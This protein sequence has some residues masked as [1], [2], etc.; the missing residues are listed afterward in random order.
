MI[1]LVSTSTELKQDKAARSEALDV[2]RSFL[3][4]APAG[5]GKTEL[6]TRRFLALLAKANTPEEILAITFTRDATAEM[7]A[8]VLE[9]LQKAQLARDAGLPDIELASAALDRS[10]ERDWSLLQ[11]PHRLNI[12][13]I[14]SLC[15]QIAHEAPL[16]SRLG[17]Q[18]QPTEDVMPLYELAARRTME[19]LDSRDRRLA[20]A[21]QDLLRLR[22]VNV[23]ECET[24]IA[25]MLCNRDQWLAEFPAE[26]L[27]SDE[28][29]EALRP[30]LEDPLRREHTRV[31]KRLKHLLSR[32]PSHG[33]ELFRLAS[34]ACT[35]NPK[36]SLDGLLE[37][38]S[39]DEMATL[40][41]FACARNFLVTADETWRKQVNVAQGFPPA[42]N[43]GSQQHIEDF[44]KLIQELQEID[45]L[46]ETFGELKSLPAESYTDEEW[47][48]I[49][50]IFM[51]L[52]HAAAQLRL[53]FAEKSRIDFVEVGLT[54]EYALQDPEIRRRWSD[55]VHHFLVDE[56]QDTSRRQYE[57]LHSI[58]REWDPS[59]KKTCFLVGDPMQSIYLF[60]QADVALFKEVQQHGFGYDAASVTFSNLTLKKN[61]RST[62]GIVN[63][64][65][66]MFA[67][68]A[69]QNAGGWDRSQFAPAIADVETP[70][71]NSVHVIAEFKDEAARI[72]S[73]DAEAAQ[74][75]EIIRQHLPAMQE[76]RATGKEFRVGVLVRAKKHVVRIAAELRKAGI[77]YRAIEIDTLTD[78]QEIKDLLS[79]VR[80]LLSPLDRIAW[81]SILRAPWC[82]L[83]LS[84]LHLLSGSDDKELLRR[85]MAEL[86]GTRIALLSKDGAQ[87]AHRLFQ[88]M[89]LA[90]SQRF[91]GEFSAS[92]S[93]FSAWIERTWYSL[94][95][96][97]CLDSNSFENAQAFFKQLA[98]ITPD[99]IEAADTLLQQRMARL[100]AQPSTDATE[101]VGVQLM[102]IHKSKGLG[103]DVVLVPALE[104]TTGR[105]MSPLLQWMAHT[106]RDS[107]Q[108]ELLLAPIGNKGNEN[109][110]TYKWV[111][112]QRSNEEDA[113]LNRLLYVAC[114]RA[115]KQLH[116]FGTLCTKKKDGVAC[117]KP[118]TGSLLATGWPYLEPIFQQRLEATTAQNQ[119]GPFLVPH[120]PAQSGILLE[121]AATAQPKGQQLQR[122]RSDWGEPPIDA[123]P[124][125]TV[126]PSN[127]RST[128]A[129]KTAQVSGI[130]LHALFQR[131]ASLRDD[132]PKRDLSRSAEHWKKVGTALS[133]HSGL[134]SRE[135]DIQVKRVLAMLHAAVADSH[136]QWILGQ[137]AEAH[138]ENAWTFSAGGRMQTVRP[139]RVF[140][141]GNKPLSTEST[142]LWILDYKTTPIDDAQSLFMEQERLHH[143]QQL[144]GY[145]QVLREALDCNLPIILAL[146]YPSLP[147]LFWWPA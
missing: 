36:Y 97:A 125:T 132:D 35:N 45:G 20:G 37:V 113:E 44:K 144:Q 6:L 118:A 86:L 54:A 67:K 16:L 120:A 83:K 58:I 76:A 139:D 61:F 75:V 73:S 30:Q 43:G 41:H 3:V 13:T 136:A 94:G 101:K 85:P 48:A 110:P 9:S 124:L 141:A 59:E 68:I 1:S 2:S 11:Q 89:N 102:T 72:D 122:L 15:L 5:S 57:L 91:S 10:R 56:F 12:Q 66:E 52:L 8:R 147:H 119:T 77:G 49:R 7:R 79:L 55:R 114:T 129:R 107:D 62:A 127:T 92:P 116:L 96:P 106:R 99:G 82:G 84:D 31:T 78:R 53:V 123:L 26:A 142:H 143:E 60:R 103:F 130:V 32:D 23:A 109:S 108:K 40:D 64:L 19:Q 33:R 111:A 137:R 74:A 69:A 126:T 17:G 140:I 71:A 14:D 104:K 28:V 115:R 4:K 34:Y 47:K 65:N 105:S 95:G 112:K 146:Y 80:A 39:I 100:F 88:I 128:Q 25:E 46:L 24:L 93:G 42:S 90:I 51:V 22:D 121:M 29:W 134:T 135:L 131:L 27:H 98:T 117:I 21:I 63:P 50:S 81:L 145:A 87:R 70:S 18:L 133:R 38:S 138:S